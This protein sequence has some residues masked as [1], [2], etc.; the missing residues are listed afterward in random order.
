MPI[1]QR[2]RKGRALT[3]FHIEQLL[4]GPD[5]V[6]IAGVGYL[7]GQRADWGFLGDAEQAEVLDTMEADWRIHGPEIA[8]LSGDAMP[9]AVERIG[10]AG[11]GPCQ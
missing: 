5:A 3:E 11:D 1:K 4:R 2:I 9:W 8:P 6:L 7:A 10:M